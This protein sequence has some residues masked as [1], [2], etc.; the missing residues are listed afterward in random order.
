MSNPT[1]NII[2]SLSVSGQFVLNN[3]LYFI[4]LESM[5]NLG[6]NNNLAYTYY[7][8]MIV[9]CLETKKEYI[10]DEK[11][12]IIYL[13]GVLSTDFVYADGTISN[14]IDYSN[15]L[16]NFYEYNE[17]YHI[18]V[19][20]IS[21]NVNLNDYLE[22]GMYVFTSKLNQEFLFSYQNAYGPNEDL[23]P[24]SFNGIYKNTTFL[25]V[26]K[27]IDIVNQEEYSV[28]QTII[29]Y[30]NGEVYS[31]IVWRSDK[32]GLPWFRNYNVI[33][34]WN[35]SN[36]E[37]P[38]Y[39]KNKPTIPSFSQTQSDWN[40]SNNAS[41]DYIKN[42]P[43]IPS[44]Q[45]QSDW[46]QRNNAALDFIKNKPAIPNTTTLGT[47][48]KID[49]GAWDVKNQSLFVKTLSLLEADLDKIRS[50]EVVLKPDYYGTSKTILT[51]SYIQIA[52]IEYK[53]T[54]QLFLER[55]VN[56]I[57]D[58]YTSTSVNRGH[59]LIHFFND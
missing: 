2:K 44:S 51:T 1:S 47:Y 26:E 15:K 27:N 59:V 19:I 39:I 18:N 56:D 54:C 11:N 42:K 41:V 37:K 24:L 22:I 52:K 12:T 34:D 43:D 28:R 33:P 16:Y 7:K 9:F 38:D 13:P 35:Q 29:N 23:Y 4:D 21:S 40:Q 31:R 50:I 53:G 10:W 17:Y 58:N 32:T 20:D 8:G 6:L 45:I 46:N 25:K 5:R 30:F 48:I 57:W 55:T 3:K 49:I 14:E 36:S